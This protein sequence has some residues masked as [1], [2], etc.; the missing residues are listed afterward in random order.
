MLTSRGRQTIALSL[1]A[2][3]AGRIL[4]VPE[5][6]GLAAAA[7]VVA[8]AALIRV[9]LAKPA[10]TVSACA[11]PSVVNAGEQA[12]VELTIEESSS[13]GLLAS[14]VVLITDDSAR[15]AAGQPPRITVPRLSRGDRASVRFAIPTNRRGVIDAGAYQVAVTDPLGLAWRRLMRSQPVRCVV[16]PR[17]E[18]LASVVPGGLDRLGSNGPRSAA[19]RLISGS[20]MLR[21]YVQGDDLRLVHW[22][23]TARVG[24]LMVRDGGDREDRERTTTKVLL[25]TGDETTPREEL[26]RAVEVA[27]AVLA[28][29]ADASRNAGSGAYRLVTTGGLDTGVEQGYARLQEVL[30]ALAGV[31]PVPGSTSRK[32]AS[33]LGLLGRPD[34]DDV[35]VIVGSFGESPPDITIIEEI[36]ISYSVVVLVLV[37]AGQASPPQGTET[38]AAMGQATTVPDAT[39]PSLA[40]SHVRELPRNLVTVPLGLGVPL[41]LAWSQDREP[42]GLLSARPHSRRSRSE[43]VVR[44]PRSSTQSP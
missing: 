5:L 36:S 7:V 42:T 40:W 23:T 3:L 17:V 4:G 34:P 35:L 31:A 39:G 2:G 30:I 37:G 8:L 21:S 38:G 6:F 20:S 26:D 14:S 22:R 11:F 9:R 27:A 18:P 32:L 19:E 12:Y 43:L 24:E 10:L 15:R 25:V 13:A 41:S 29:A 1:V 33:A 44:G 28:V 16:L